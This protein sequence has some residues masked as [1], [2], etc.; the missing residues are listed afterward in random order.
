LAARLLRFSIP[1]LIL[2]LGFEVLLARLGESWPVSLVVRVEQTAQPSLYG[3]GLFSQQ[4]GLYKQRSIARRQP[5]IL[6]LGS[7]RV[8]QFRR[9]MFRPLD[10]GFYNAG[11]MIQNLGDLEQLAESIEAGGLAAPRA[12]LIGI[13]PWW[14]AARDRPIPEGWSA[15]N[16]AHDAVLRPAAH[17]AVARNLVRGRGWSWQAL[18]AGARGPSPYY[19]QPAIG[20]A[21]LRGQGFREDGSYQYDPSMLLAFID[22]PVYH[23]REQPPVTERIARTSHQFTPADGVASARLE[24]LVTSLGRLRAQGI[25]VYALLPPF[26]TPA[27]AALDRSP[28][29]GAWWRAYHRALP[30]RLA[31]VGVDGLDAGTPAEH[32]LGDVSMI[33]GFHPSEVF[34]G[35]LLRDLVRALPADRLLAQIDVRALEALLD[36][37]ALPLAFDLPPGAERPGFRPAFDAVRCA[38]RAQ[39]GVFLGAR[40]MGDPP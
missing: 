16:D 13:D 39:D 26:S 22:R 40:P 12:V 6:V 4:F 28:A 24:H 7:S 5:R 32:G 34:A 19:Q 23:D 29:L 37:A 33:D 38:R 11:G 25:E 36:R 15:T 20:A 17:L 18:V 9:A 8:Q 31:A 35:H 10:A 14:L 27:A 2:V 1:V 3:R 21:A 30:Q